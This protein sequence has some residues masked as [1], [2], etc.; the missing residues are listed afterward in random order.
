MALPR[1]SIPFLDHFGIL[2]GCALV[3]SLMDPAVKDAP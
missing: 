2:K 1:D 3:T